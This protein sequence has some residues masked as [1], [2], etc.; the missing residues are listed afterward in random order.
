MLSC[1]YIFISLEYSIYIHQNQ[2]EIFVIPARSSSSPPPPH[3]PGASVS[4]HFMMKN[5][6]NGGTYIRVR[7]GS[8]IAI[9]SATV[10]ECSF[11]IE[12]V[13]KNNPWWYVTRTPRPV[14]AVQVEYL[15]ELRKAEAAKV[16]PSS[17]MQVQ[18]TNSAVTFLWPTILSHDEN[19]CVPKA[20]VNWYT[21]SDT[22]LVPD[23]PLAMARCAPSVT[24]DV[25]ACSM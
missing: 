8:N 23:P 9:F 12:S 18:A 24:R 4:S 2:C 17:W 1:T 21:H 22:H 5:N 3:L 16:A 10:V 6:Q 15:V 19:E 14:S 25:V 20:I 7:A 13:R 11:C